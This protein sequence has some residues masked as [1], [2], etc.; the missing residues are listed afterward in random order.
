MIPKD[1][2]LGKLNTSLNLILKAFTLCDQNRF[3][4]CMEEISN[5]V[6][7]LC[8]ALDMIENN[9]IVDEEV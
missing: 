7:E 4:E 8:N 9:E 2:V 1:R 3:G 6:T 5:A